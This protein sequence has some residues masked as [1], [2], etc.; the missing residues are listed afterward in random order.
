[1]R[2]NWTECKFVE[3]HQVP[4]VGLYVT[5][6]RYGE[7]RL[8]RRTYEKMGEP[9]AVQ[10][11]F[12]AA[13]QRF[14]LKPTHLE[15]RNAFPVLKKGYAGGRRIRV[16]GVLRENNIDIPDTLRFHDA[17]FDDE[18]ILILDLRTARV[19]QSAKGHPRNIARK[20]PDQKMS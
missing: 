9:A 2:A 12:D 5:L 18:G 17:D 13:N 16:L 3:R 7:F 11:L 4:W 1:M 14:G 10:I 20:N 6:T 15:M 19:P 8:G